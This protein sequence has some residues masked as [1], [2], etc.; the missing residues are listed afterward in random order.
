MRRET[1]APLVTVRY[2]ADC[3]FCCRMVGILRALDRK[4]LV[5]TQ[6]MDRRCNDEGCDQMIVQA[7]SGQDYRGFDG[8]VLLCRLFP[9]TYPFTL[10]A[11]RSAIR[12]IGHWVYRWIARNRYRFSCIFSMGKSPVATDKEV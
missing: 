2:D 4:G 8:I 5:R 9:L 7:P 12:L 3:P 11:H 6:P 10:I 1:G